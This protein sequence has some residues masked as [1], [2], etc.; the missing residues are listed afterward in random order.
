MKKIQNTL[1]GAAI[2]LTSFQAAALP[3]A[4]VDARSLAMGGTGVAAGSIA[5]ASTFNPALLAASREGEDFNFSLAL[6][7]LARDDGIIDAVDELQALNGSG[8]DLIQQFSVDSTAYQN[9]VAAVAAPLSIGD[10]TGDAA[11]IAAAANLQTS[12]TDLTTSL[13]SMNNKPIELGVTVGVNL[14]VPGETLGISVFANSRIIAAGAITDI[15]QDT[16]L[17]TNIVDEITTP[18]SIANLQSIADPFAGGTTANTSLTLTGGAVTEVG[19][20]LATKIFGIAIGVTPKQLRID[21]L[22]TVQGVNS[23]NTNDILDTGESFSDANFDVGVAMDLGLF[24]VGAVGKNM[25]EQEYTL[26]SGNTVIIEPQLRAGISFDAGWATLT[27]DQ[28][29][30]VNK[31]VISTGI[32]AI[33]D[34]RE[35]QYTSVGVEVDLSLVQIRAGMRTDNTGNTEDVLTAGIGIHALATVDIAVAGNDQGVEAVIQVGLRW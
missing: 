27:M 7:L 3:F 14:T 25:I 21:T 2:A 29:L 15:D 20:A 11:V 22:E 26:L 9:A 12:A 31:G 10:I 35:S 8:N 30:T 34:L 13:N 4:G 28:D 19:V 17:I 18:T 5:N 33:D 16:V 24:K 6:G 32:A 1:I 23:T